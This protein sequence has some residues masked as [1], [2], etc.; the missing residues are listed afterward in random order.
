MEGF[1]WPWGFIIHRTVYTP[2]SDELWS[3]CLNKI[4]ECVRRETDEFG[5]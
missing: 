3:A 4:E 2:E 5:E 1:K